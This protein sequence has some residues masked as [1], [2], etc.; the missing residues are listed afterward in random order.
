[1]S[2]CAFVKTNQLLQDCD[3]ALW[4]PFLW[5]SQGH[6]WSTQVH[7]GLQTLP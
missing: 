3:T 1:M 5:I 4:P 7:K 6:S 2:V